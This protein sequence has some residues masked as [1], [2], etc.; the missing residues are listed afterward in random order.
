MSKAL[1]SGNVPFLTRNTRLLFGVTRRDVASCTVKKFQIKED[2]MHDEFSVYC[3][4]DEAN[5][6]EG[7][8]T[9]AKNSD[10]HELSFRHSGNGKI[11]PANY[12]PIWIG[13]VSPDQPL[14]V[15]RFAVSGRSHPLKCDSAIPGMR[16][17]R[18]IE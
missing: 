8:L 11:C 9:D 6:P 16:F 7:K 2:N 12:I 13:G 1:T 15:T 14:H 3:V 5:R 17:A 18:R 4:R 10:L